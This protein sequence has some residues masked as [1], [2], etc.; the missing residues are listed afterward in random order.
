MLGS[1]EEKTLNVLR[2]AGKLISKVFAPRRKSS[3]KKN[4]CMLRVSFS[5]PQDGVAR[6]FEVCLPPKTLKEKERNLR[7]RVYC[8][9]IPDHPHGVV[10]LVLSRD[11]SAPKHDPLRGAAWYCRLGNGDELR[12]EVRI[13]A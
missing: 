2:D 7:A 13:N 9:E 6:S 10:A 12:A 5:C 1:L 3:E 11:T 4:G 8:A